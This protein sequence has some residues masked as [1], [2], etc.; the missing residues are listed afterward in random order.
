MGRRW[1]LTEAS[2]KAVG[3]LPIG[4]TP[5]FISDT[6]A[7]G[8]GEGWVADSLGL[9]VFEWVWQLTGDLEWAVDKGVCKM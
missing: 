7:A 4:M 1:R 6:L 9:K 5:L 8:E 2:E 3:M